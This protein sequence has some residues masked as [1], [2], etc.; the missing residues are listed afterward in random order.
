MFRPLLNFLRNAAISRKSSSAFIGDHLMEQ[1][2]VSNLAF[3]LPQSVKAEATR[4]KA[5]HGEDASAISR[6]GGADTLLHLK[7]GYVP[8]R[9][10]PG[11]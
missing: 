11:Y 7:E 1:K 8:I 5:S 9:R 4:L 2:S 3:T 10:K 6:Q